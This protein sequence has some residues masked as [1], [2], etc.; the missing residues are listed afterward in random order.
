MAKKMVTGL[1][2]ANIRN[3]GIE[4]SP[5]H[6]FTDDGNRFR[7]FIYKGI[8]MTQCRADGECYLA[9]RID[10]LDN[11]F[12]WKEWS[13]TNEYKLEDK[14]NGV[15]E[16]DMEELIENLEKIIAKR[17]EMNAKASAEEIDMTEITRK[18]FKE[19]Q[20][21]S[22][23]IYQVQTT[24]KWWKL[25]EYDLR[26]AGRYLESL[27]KELDKVKAINFNDLDR[28]DKMK[29][30]ESLRDYGYVCMDPNGFYVKQLKGY[31]AE[32]K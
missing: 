10:Y 24:L 31:M 30:V 22:Q 28:V 14:F 29:Y 16:F 17:D 15:S 6:D 13:K 12:T 32:T 3:T 25:R 23:F 26:N 4:L 20:D 1:T 21:R 18:V 9:I 19:I 8:P 5:E 7:G 27:I 11:Q 2:K